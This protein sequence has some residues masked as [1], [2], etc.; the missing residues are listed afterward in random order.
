MGITRGPDL[1][2]LGLQADPQDHQLS[3]AIF[4]QP[5]GGS[6][7]AVTLRGR[8]GEVRSQSDLT[9]LAVELADHRW[10]WIAGDF[11]QA[12]LVHV[13][14]TVKINDLRFPWP[15]RR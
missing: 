9:E 6:G 8:P 4:T 12:D 14:D 1:W 10:F 11:P 15:G 7:P 5:I 3:V 13:A 2:R